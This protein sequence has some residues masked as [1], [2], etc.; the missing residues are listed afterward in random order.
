MDQAKVVMC[1]TCRKSVP[2]NTVRYVPKGKDYL[3]IVC[4]SCR[5]QSSGEEKNNKKQGDSQKTVKNM[6]ERLSY[7]CER[8]K[9]PFKHNPKGSSNLLCPYCGK[10]DK[11]RKTN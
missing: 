11:L 8:C 9:F 3:M 6:T 4:A 1:D 10:A 5:G 2:A 7:V